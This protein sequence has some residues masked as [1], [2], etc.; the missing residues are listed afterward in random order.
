MSILADVNP[1]RRSRIARAWTWLIAAWVLTGAIFKLFWGTPALL[2][3][4]VRDLPLE[5]GLTY[6]LAIGIELAISSV[7]LTRP[8]WGWWMQ[9]ALLLVFDLVL[10]TQIAAGET[11]CGCFGTKLSVDPRI[12]L[13]ADSV[14]LVGLLATRPWSSLGAGLRPVVPVALGALALALPWFLERQVKTGEAVANGQPV[15]LWQDLPVE[16]WIG[17]DVWDTALGQPPLNEYI[18]V[19]KLPLDGLWVFWRQTCEHCAKHL[20]H[21]AAN[22]HGERLITLIQLEEPNDTLA[23]R[24][25]NAMPDGNFVQHARL[26]PS[27]SYVLQTPAEIQL[28]G[29]KIVAAREA[30]TP[31]TGL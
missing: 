12:M 23:N 3:R 27:I 24:V 7:A 14:L 13:A 6:N 2:P 26:P 21:M 10:T 29:G 16:K 17:K 19:Q 18:D 8:R 11:N 25:V 9:A 30:V 22:E 28:E 15:G 1:G 5:L 31:E 20:A 4:A